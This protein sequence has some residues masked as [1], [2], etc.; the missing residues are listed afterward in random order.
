MN[1]HTRHK[2]KIAA[3]MARHDKVAR[4]NASCSRKLRK[5]EQKAAEAWA[6]LQEL[7]AL[8]KGTRSHE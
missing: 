8:V 4:R 5:H 1:Q 7:L 6:N 2:R 3:K